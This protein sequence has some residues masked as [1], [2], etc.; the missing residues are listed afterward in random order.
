MKGELI[1]FVS[2]NPPLLIVFGLLMALIGIFIG[3][4]VG[5]ISLRR[6]VTA[7]LTALECE[8]FIQ[9]S[10]INNVG[11]GVIAYDKKGVLYANSTLDTLQGFISEGKFPKTL[12]VFLN[13]YDKNNQLKSNYLLG[14]ENGI[15]TTR[16]N[17][18]VDKK[19]YEIK[20]IR[21]TFDTGADT[22][23]KGETVEIVI[24]DDITQIK[25]DE[26]RQ[27]DLAANVSHELKTPLTVIKATD[28]L[29]ENIR[30]E[31]PPSYEEISKWGKRIKINVERM[32]DIVK[33]F[34]VLS[35]TS[36]VNRMGIFDVTEC[37][38]KAINSVS[39]YTG[40]DNVNIIFEKSSESPLAYGNDS[41]T[42][43]V[44]INL[45][46]NAI[47][48]INYE[49]KTEPNE[50]RVRVDYVEDRINISVGDN[51]M[52]IPEKDLS[53]LFERFYRVDN[54]GS[55]EVG[56]SGIGLAIAK[57]IADMHDGSI[58]VASKL[59]SGSTF[60]FMLPSASAALKSAYD[61]AKAGVI[62]DNKFYR[63][64]SGF[65]ALQVCEAT[66]SIGYDDLMELVEEYENIPET[67]INERDKK[68]TELLKAFGDE[69]YEDLVEELLYVDPDMMDDEGFDE[70]M[71]EDMSEDLAPAAEADAEAGESAAEAPEEE[72]K[73]ESAPVLTSSGLDKEE[74]KKMLT[75]EILPR[76]T[77][78]KAGKAQDVVPTVNSQEQIPLIHPTSERK[79]YN[80]IAK[81]QGKKRESL[82][83]HLKAGAGNSENGEN[84]KGQVRSRVRQMLDDNDNLNG[85]K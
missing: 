78:Y 64:V 28:F 4:Y 70:E 85:N 80:N 5:N 15:N 3:Y 72:E 75:R 62:S 48:Y 8:G 50:I 54:S 36:Q 13:T 25:D 81:K 47:K 59:R 43:R 61:D 42:M 49:G 20:I 34:L 29:I 56:G 37:I 24:I 79:M 33:D 21:K 69:R 38:N 12:E 53:H 1:R 58:A 51:G 52:G 18:I 68:L 39:E 74:A 31:N 57:E 7:K 19:I 30:P 14:L 83:E 44:V 73:A 82:F 26:R 45:L 11:L 66:R 35:Q 67:N 65:L 46:T 6:S 76:S 27:K 16:A 9:K 71:P 55:R 60:T 2:G 41:L 32:E 23:F 40:R 17:Y 77:Q 22:P 10:I 63:A 84:E